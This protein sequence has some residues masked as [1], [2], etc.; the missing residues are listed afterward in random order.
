VVRAKQLPRVRS[1]WRIPLIAGPLAV[2]LMT[3]VY[4]GSVVDPVAHLGGLPVSIVNEDAG[5][6]VGGHR[7][8]RY[9]RKG[10]PRV[11]PDVLTSVQRSGNTYNKPASGSTTT[12]APGAPGRQ[13][14]PT[15]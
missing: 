10:L 5:A 14:T 1:I 4:I 9:D 15:S 13:P 6:P 2:V 12:V 11:H 3:C 8:D 7:V